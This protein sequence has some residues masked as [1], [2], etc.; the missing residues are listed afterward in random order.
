M[1]CFFFTARDE[2]FFFFVF[3]FVYVVACNALGMTKV[4]QGDDEDRKAEYI[5]GTGEGS[6]GASK[7]PTLRLEEGKTKFMRRKESAPRRGPEW[8]GTATAPA[9]V[10]SEVDPKLHSLS[11][12][13]SNLV[14]TFAY[15]FPR[16]SPGRVVR[17]KRVTLLRSGDWTAGIGGHTASSSGAHRPQQSAGDE[18]DRRCLS[19]HWSLS[20]AV[21][22]PPSLLLV[23]IEFRSRVT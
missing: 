14:Y 20:D 4:G 21:T 17:P 5:A 1:R 8:F 2:V 19:M 9:S 22:P 6:D 3:L 7:G 11:F 16:P 12:S 13:I 18:L 23:E 10:L 15:D